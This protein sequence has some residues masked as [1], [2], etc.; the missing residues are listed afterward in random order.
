[1]QLGTGR[2]DPK[3]YGQPTG[4]HITTAKSQSQVDNYIDNYI[5]SSLRIWGAAA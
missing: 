2:P 4:A 3:R 5:D 1:M